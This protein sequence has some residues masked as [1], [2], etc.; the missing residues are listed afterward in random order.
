[1]V[2]EIEQGEEIF[3]QCEECG[4]VYKTMEWVEKCEAFCKQNKSCSVEITKHAR[5]Q[6]K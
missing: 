5:E 1:M 3:F 2:K 4:F 6:G